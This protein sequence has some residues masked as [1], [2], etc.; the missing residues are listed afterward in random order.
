MTAENGRQVRESILIIFNKENWNKGIYFKR[1]EV[2][3]G[4]KEAMNRQVGF[5]LKIKYPSSLGSLVL[6]QESF[7]N[8]KFERMMLERRYGGRKSGSINTATLC[9]WNQMMS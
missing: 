1:I 8:C 7:H 3:G 9:K 6:F 4:A 5:D 2:T